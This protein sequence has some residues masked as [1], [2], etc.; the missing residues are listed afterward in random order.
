MTNQHPLADDPTKLTQEELDK[1]IGQ[2][3]Q[4]YYTARRM[5]MNYGVLHQLDIMLQG[6]EYERMRR[7]QMPDDGRKVVIDTDDNQIK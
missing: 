1:K 6:L 3:T 4:R 5:N 2:L 7:A